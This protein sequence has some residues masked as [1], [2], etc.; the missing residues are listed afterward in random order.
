MNTSKPFLDGVIFGTDMD[1]G[2]FD[3]WVSDTKRE[4]TETEWE[5]FS[6]D[7][8]IDVNYSLD[9]IRIKLENKIVYINIYDLEHIKIKNNLIIMRG[10]EVQCIFDL[11]KGT[12]E[13]EYTR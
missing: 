5:I 6:P 10:H 13:S 4:I 2:D 12:F 9:L 11:I 7:K 1:D 8:K 3:E